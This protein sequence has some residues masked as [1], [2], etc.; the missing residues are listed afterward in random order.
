[1]K[2][3]V[4]FDKDGDKVGDLDSETYALSKLGRVK[5]TEQELQVNVANGL[6]IHAFRVLVKKGVIKPYS[7]LFFYNKAT[8]PNL[9][10]PIIIDPKGEISEYPLGFLDSY[11]DIISKLI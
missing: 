4:V 10:R 6:V 9:S 3:H 1:M 8:D 11:S 2:L 5:G 7:E